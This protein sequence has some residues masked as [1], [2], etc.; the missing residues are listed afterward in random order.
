MHDW[1][2]RENE[3]MADRG[4]RMAEEGAM[5]LITFASSI[6]GRSKQTS[7][8]REKLHYNMFMDVDY[9]LVIK[10]DGSQGA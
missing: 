5:T 7:L 2:R 9:M 8:R 10:A 1:K 3:Q 6:L 4:D